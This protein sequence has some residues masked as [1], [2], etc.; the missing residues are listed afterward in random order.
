MALKT[1]KQKKKAV[2]GASLK[3]VAQPVRA[4]TVRRGLGRGLS[5]LIP[6][7]DMDFLSRVARGD[8]TAPA[9]PVARPAR[10][11]EQ[12]KENSFR[13][14]TSSVADIPQDEQSAVPSARADTSDTQ[15]Q[16]APVQWLPVNAI[17]ANPYQPRRTFASQE[18]GDLVQS[19]REHGILQPILVRPLD[20][21]HG[22]VAYQLVAG[23]RRWRAAQ[24][25]NLPEVPAIV[26]GVS[27]QQALE[28]A[29]IENIQRHDISAL[30]AA[31]AYRRLADDFQL[32]QEQIAGRVGK[33]RSAVANTMRLLEL[34]AECQQAIEDGKLSE[35]HGRA[36]LSVI[37]EG[38]RRAL[39]RRI[40][41]DGLSV[42][43]AERL[44]RAPAPA[45][46]AERGSENATQELLTQAELKDIEQRLQRAMGT[47]LHITPKKQG[48][49]IVLEYF[50]L[51]ELD[52][53]VALLSTAGQSSAQAANSASS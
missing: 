28:L 5:A 7:A 27:D 51:E 24:Q 26:R 23:E 4:T 48:G 12:A 20:G 17:E 50:S 40:L 36:L 43:E 19:I 49:Q 18:M 25:A 35:G 3:P 53:L 32:S 37:N 9:V 44:S 38:A 14:E 30:D 47:R 31:H 34:P 10:S 16:T 29:L 21:A 45:P 1:S 52:R 11:T 46:S 42:R 15:G 13:S 33:S 41:R 8:E 22:A 39:F 2:A 6:D